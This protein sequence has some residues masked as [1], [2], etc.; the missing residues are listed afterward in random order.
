MAL[1]SNASGSGTA[2]IS[3]SGTGETFEVQL[4][5]NG[6]SGS[7][8]PVVGYNIYRATGSNSSYRLM[9][10]SVNATRTYTDTS[11]QDGTSYSYYIE[12]GDSSG[13]QSA[14][15]SPFTVDIP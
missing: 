4:T 5:W 14:P 3:L 6:P 15:S 13:N 10:P 1:T 8:D 2:T 9:N 7:T 11:V 12:T